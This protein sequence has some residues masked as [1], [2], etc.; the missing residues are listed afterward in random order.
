MPLIK[1]DDVCVT[2]GTRTLLDHV[3]L[4]IDPGE[5]VALVGL[6]G[7]GKSTLLKVVA[8]H[9]LPDAGTFWQDPAI[10]IAELAQMLPAADGRRVSDVVMAGL[11][12]VVELRARYDQLIQAQDMASMRE[13][14][15][16]Q[17]ELEAP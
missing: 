15:Q 7:A 2:F 5:R 6:N 14:E 11:H 16:L 3:N 13:L 4:Q 1:F 17:H 8:G 9:L 12:E 10:R